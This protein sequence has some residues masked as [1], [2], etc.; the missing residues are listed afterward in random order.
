MFVFCSEKTIS[1]IKRDAL[2][3]TLRLRLLNVKYS[4]DISQFL[5][6]HAL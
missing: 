5:S 1:L 3:N 4:K 6:V 2:H